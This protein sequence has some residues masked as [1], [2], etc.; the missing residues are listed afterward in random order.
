MAN[1][2]GHL[3]TGAVWPDLAIFSTLG[4]NSKPV[5][6]IIL[7]K[8]PTLWGDFY[9]GVKIIQFSSELIFGQLL[10][11][12]GDFYLVTLYGCIGECME[13]L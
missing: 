2:F 11:T 1:W 4:N 3:G 12:L 6:T 5:A 10:Q 13:A 8:S 9:K 7:T